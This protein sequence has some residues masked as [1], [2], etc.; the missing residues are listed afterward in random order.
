MEMA[1]VTNK[2]QWEMILNHLTMHGSITDTDA[3]DLYGCHRLAARIADLKD[4]GYDIVGDWEHGKN[5]YGKRI[6]YK[7]YRLK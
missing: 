1:I 3:I 7:R 2:A 5:R 6:K 4:K